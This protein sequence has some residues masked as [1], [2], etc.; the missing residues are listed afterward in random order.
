[1]MQHARSGQRD[2]HTEGKLGTS[3][4]AVDMDQRRSIDSGS[5]SRRRAGRLARRVAVLVIGTGAAVAFSAP[6]FATAPRG[7]KISATQATFA[8]P[9]SSTSTWTIRLW[10]HGTLE[11]SDTG[12][13]GTLTVVVPVTS[14]CKFQA[15]VSET[16]PGGQGFF[17]SGTRATVLGCGPLPTIAGDIYLCP[18]AGATTTEVAGG[19]LGVTGPQTLTPQSN[20]MAPTPVLSGNYTMTA[21]SPSGY[22]FVACGGSS[23]VAANGSS[24]TEVVPVFIGDTGSGPMSPTPCLAEAESASSTSRPRQP[25]PEPV[26]VPSTKEQAD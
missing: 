5:M 18:A 12:T 1:M 2:V 11:G 13:S 16:L 14:D 20:P 4:G 21:S 6:A 25:P 24:A 19:M 9:T 3:H 23:S 26:E 8:V 7:P 15:D 17:Y 22:M 10:S